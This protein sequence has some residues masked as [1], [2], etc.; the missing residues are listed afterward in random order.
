MPGLAHWVILNHNKHLLLENVWTECTTK[1]PQTQ[2]VEEED[3]WSGLST[4][5]TL[6][7]LANESVV[8]ID[9]ID[10]DRAY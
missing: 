8:V 10:S 5:T 3:T 4:R 9:I 1:I 2:Q 6:L 7:F